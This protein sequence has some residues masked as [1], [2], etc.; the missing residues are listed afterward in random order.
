MEL[1]CPECG[2]TLTVDDQNCPQ[3]NV[4]IDWAADEI[5]DGEDVNGILDAIIEETRSVQTAEDDAGK[6][7]VEYDETDMV[8]SE[9]GRTDDTLLEEEV[10]DGDM[11]GSLDDREVEVKED[12]YDEKIDDEDSEMDLD[13]DSYD[14]TEGDEG[15]PSDVHEGSGSDIIPDEE[16]PESDLSEEVVEEEDVVSS[17]M[18]PRR[19]YVNTFSVIGISA[20]VMALLGV[21]GIIV[22]MNYDTWI[23]GDAESI[24][25]D[26]QRTAIYLVVMFTIILFAISA[27]DAYRSKNAAKP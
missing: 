27:F 19:L 24:I 12:M 5:P 6:D 14:E 11:D 16:Q 20:M 22:L 25:G 7:A 10:H 21:V 17:P 23:K 1:A 13:E 8:E 15:G 18:K 26:S 4:E 9:E 3:C 2:A